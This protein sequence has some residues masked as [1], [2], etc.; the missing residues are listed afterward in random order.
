MVFLFW[1]DYTHVTWNPRFYNSA[2]RQIDSRALRAWHEL[3]ISPLC[4]LRVSYA[5]VPV[6]EAFGQNLEV[7]AMHVHWVVTRVVIFDDH[8]YTCV[9][10]EIVHIPFLIISQHVAQLLWPMLLIGVGKEQTGSSGKEV[11]PWLAS[12]SNASLIYVNYHITE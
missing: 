1:R 9:T 12:K 7:M 2:V 4:V 8:A 11:F 10:A 6:A 5:T 3:D